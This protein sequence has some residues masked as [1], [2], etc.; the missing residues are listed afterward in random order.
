[1]F[2]CFATINNK[3]G[4]IYFHRVGRDKKSKVVFE[5]HCYVK[6]SE[7]KTQEERRALDEE[8]AKFRISYRNKR[9]KLC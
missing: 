3:L 8:F 9:Y 6:K 4:E 7:F 2:W 5:G 1:M